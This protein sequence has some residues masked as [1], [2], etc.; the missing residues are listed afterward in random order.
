MKLPN[1][2]VLA[3]SIISLIGL[4]PS[5]AAVF[6]NEVMVDPAGSD[7][8]A[9][10]VEI[11]GTAGTD[12]GGWVIS[13]GGPGASDSAITIPAGAVIPGDGFYLIGNTSAVSN[14]DLP[15][16]GATGIPDL[17]FTNSGEFIGLWDNSFTPIDGLIW[18][19]NVAGD[20]NAPSGQDPF[21]DGSLI[22]DNLMGD[23][24]NPP[25]PWAWTASIGSSGD[26]LIRNPD[27]TGAW[28]LSSTV[29]GVATPGAT[30]AVPEPST[31]ILVA[32]S[33]LAVFARRGRQGG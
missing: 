6:L 25:A 13:D 14:A 8:G 29:L 2:R 10:W 26:S 18:V 24:T 9:E 21:G 5:R 12:I 27:G 1:L 11:F 7:T 4:F 22:I 23:I 33:L 16:G 17:S 3:F 20:S 28:T 30:N 15:I 31:G 32:V 19:E